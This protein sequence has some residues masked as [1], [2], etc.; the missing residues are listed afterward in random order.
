[1]VLFLI[2]STVKQLK[3]VDAYLWALNPVV[4]AT[5]QGELLPHP[6]KR[7]NQYNIPICTYIVLF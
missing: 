1:M 6:L 2:G 5:N 7:V 3:M 4:K